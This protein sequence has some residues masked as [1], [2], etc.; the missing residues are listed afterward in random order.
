[1]AS[2]QAGWKADFRCCGWH[3]VARRWKR[4]TAFTPLGKWRADLAHHSSQ[5]L[6]EIEGGKQKQMTVAMQEI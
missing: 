2:R 1:M 5:T 6:I 3:W 4:S